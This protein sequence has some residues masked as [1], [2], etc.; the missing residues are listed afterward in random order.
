MNTQTKITLMIVVTLTS[1][2]AVDALAQDKAGCEKADGTFCITRGDVQ[3]LEPS[4]AQRFWRAWQYQYQFNEQP[5]FVVATVN[6]SAQ[7]VQNPEKYLQQHTIT[8][9]F[10]ELFPNTTN[11]A[12][13]VGAIYSNSTDPNKAH[14]RLAMAD[15]LCGKGSV[16]VLQCLASGGRGAGNFMERFLSAVTVNFSMGERDEIQQGVLV[17]NFPLAQ[18]YGPAGEVDFDP[19]TSLFVTGAN[20]KSAVAALKGVNNDSGS[21]FSDGS[22]TRC[23]VK[24]PPT[25]STSKQDEDG[26]W[27]SCVSEFGTPRFGASKRAEKIAYFGA[28]AIPKF[29]FKAVSQFDYLKNGGVLVAIPGLQRSLKNYS[30]IWDFRRAIASTSDRLAVMAAYRTYSDKPQDPAAAQAFLAQ[31]KL[32]ITISGASRGYVPVP[33]TFAIEACQ[34]L[35]KSTGAESYALACATATSVEIGPAESVNASVLAKRPD[36]NECHWPLGV[37]VATNAQ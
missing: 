8:F 13:I 35:A 9:Q 21:L 23:F 19:N 36:Q 34:I 17:P 22:E 31:P 10:S 37:D 27:K 4:A 11:L 2:I 12:S 28:L 16:P 1:F 29:Q 25:G 26:A 33:G 20:W 32:C 7:I 6:G 14:E 15:G 3:S 30:F 24:N 18:H 5:L